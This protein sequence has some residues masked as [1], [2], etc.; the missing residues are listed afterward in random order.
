MA[1]STCRAAS[2]FKARLAAQKEYADLLAKLG[3][4][5]EEVRS[6]L[7]AHP[8]LATGLHR[9]PHAAAGTAA[10][11]LAEIAPYLGKSANEIRVLKARALAGAAV[12][13]VRGLPAQLAGLRKKLSKRA[14]ILFTRAKEEWAEARPVVEAQVKEK[15]KERVDKVMRRK[16]PDA[17]TQAAAVA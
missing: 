11:R 13:G 1:R 14:P 10:D 12:A 9:S 5:A 8:E 17:G 3:T 16:T 4:T 6:F 2:L 15:I 7:A